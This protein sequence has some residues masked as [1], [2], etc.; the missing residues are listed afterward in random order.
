MD[1][2]YLSALSALAGSVIGALTSTGTTWLMQRGQARVAQL[3]HEKTR[4]EEL[5][6]EFIIAASNAYGDA[7]VSSEPQ[8]HE[9]VGLNSMISRMRVVST[10][11]VI[12]CADK[13][14][15]TIVETYFSPNRSVRELHELIKHGAGI[16]PLK[17]FS[18]AVREEVELFRWV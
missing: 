10:P 3:A 6:R 16:D 2:A 12:S 8:F 17:E 9:L 15:S 18:E 4:R 7:L 1:I 11:R 13:I 5:Y 14:M